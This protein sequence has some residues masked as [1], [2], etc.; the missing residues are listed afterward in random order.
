MTWPTGV[1]YK[2]SPRQESDRCGDAFDF[3]DGHRER[4]RLGDDVIAHLRREYHDDMTLGMA[5]DFVN[6][7]ADGGPVTPWYLDFFTVFRLGVPHS[8]LLHH[9]CEICSSAASSA[10][11]TASSLR[12]SLSQVLLNRWYDLKVAAIGRFRVSEWTSLSLP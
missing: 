2:D 4:G 10:A 8:A 7:G 3:V 5:I 6:G 9:G 12:T 11:T 1:F